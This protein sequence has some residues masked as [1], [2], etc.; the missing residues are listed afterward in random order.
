MCSQ[1]YFQ[2]FKV[3]PK[4]LAAFVSV[5]SMV[6]VIKKEKIAFNCFSQER[7]WQNFD[8]V[9]ISVRGSRP[10]KTVQMTEAEVFS[11]NHT[12]IYIVHLILINSCLFIFINILTST[13]LFCIHFH[14]WILLMNDHLLSIDH[15]YLK[16]ASHSTALYYFSSNMLTFT[17]CVLIKTPIYYWTQIL[18]LLT[19]FKSHI[20][21]LPLQ[22]CYTFHSKIFH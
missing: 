14:L 3:L 21:M 19:V 20:L 5:L 6:P 16:T 8:F 4:Q 12:F 15:H 11:F 13:Y 7:F 10:G 18:L 2:G 22:S 17:C 9:F 1:L